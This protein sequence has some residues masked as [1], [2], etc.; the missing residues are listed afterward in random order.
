MGGRY[1]YISC[2]IFVVCTLS[3]DIRTAILMIWNDVYCSLAPLH[4]GIS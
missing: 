2:A 4:L 1:I 3:N